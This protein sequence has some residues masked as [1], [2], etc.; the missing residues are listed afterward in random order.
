MKKRFFLIFS[1]LLLSALACGK[2]GIRAQIATQTARSQSSQV[3]TQIAPAS[4][5]TPQQQASQSVSRPRLTRTPRAWATQTRLPAR[6]T[7]T[8]PPAVATRR[9]S[10]TE[11]LADIPYCV[12]D[13]GV[14]LLLDIYLPRQAKTPAPVAM[15]VHG[16][17]WTGGD[18]SEGAG[19]LFMQELLIRGYIFVTINYRLAPEYIFPAQIEDV[20]CAVRFLRANAGQYGIDPQRIGAI[21]GSAGGHLVSLMGTVGEEIPWG[22]L[23]YED[24]FENQPSLVQAV[25]DLFGPADLTT[26]F[27]QG[28]GRQ[29]WRLFG[30]NSID[31]LVFKLYSPVTYASPDDPPFLI[32]H[33]DQDELVPLAQSQA[34]YDALSSVKVPVE[35]VVVKNAGHSFRPMGG[36]IEPAMLELTRMVANFFDLYLKQ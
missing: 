33:G 14:P 31:D 1:M 9:A 24:R 8:L 30:G 10:Q 5:E 15:Y 28:D 16:G 12:T 36:E 4:S 27:P 22:K 32:L 29:P 17:G 25:V 34:L 3:A 6:P 19:T 11:T 35:L 7:R 13:K 2:G 21:G 18:K 23:S 20:L 26:L